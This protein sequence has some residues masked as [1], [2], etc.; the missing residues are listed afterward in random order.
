MVIYLAEF[1]SLAGVVLWGSARVARFNFVQ[2]TK[3]AKNV[4]NEHKIYQVVIN[5]SKCP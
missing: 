1:N 4:P 2:D 3:T 5:Y